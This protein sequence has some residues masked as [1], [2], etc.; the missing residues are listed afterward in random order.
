MISPIINWP[1]FVYLF[2]AL[3]FLSLHLK[4]PWSIALRLRI[5]WTS[6]THRINTPDR[7]NKKRTK[8][9]TNE[10]ANEQSRYST[11]CMLLRKSKSRNL[12]HVNWRGEGHFPHCWSI[13]QWCNKIHRCPGLT[14]ACHSQNGVHNMIKFSMKSTILTLFLHQWSYIQERPSSSDSHDATF[15]SSFPFPPSPSAPSPLLNGVWGYHPG[16]FWNQ[17]KDA[18]RWVLHHFRHKHQHIY[19][20]GWF[21][22]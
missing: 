10:I 8:K 13:Q 9:R 12:L 21:S 7:H 17:I 22:P 2:V 4:F 6:S 20:P 5:R 15:P 19:L 16:N 18:C 11:I 14:S 3:G 1:N